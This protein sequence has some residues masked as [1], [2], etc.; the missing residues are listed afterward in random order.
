MLSYSSRIHYNVVKTRYEYKYHINKHSF[1]RSS[2]IYL[3]YFV[4][5][6]VHAAIT[7]ALRFWLLICLVTFNNY[8]NFV[9]FYVFCVT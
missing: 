5:V 8:S 2:F 3:D 7:L 6:Y 4:Y 9:Y 1:Y